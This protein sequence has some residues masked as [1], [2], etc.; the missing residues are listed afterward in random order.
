MTKF[1]LALYTRRYMVKPA[2]DIC[3]HLATLLKSGDNLEW[4]ER[5]DLTPG[6]KVIG[7]QVAPGIDRLGV[8][9]A[10]IKELVLCLDR[11]QS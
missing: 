4:Q 10:I 5:G 7:N 9:L 3:Y 8:L 1:S 2:S 6:D 11:G